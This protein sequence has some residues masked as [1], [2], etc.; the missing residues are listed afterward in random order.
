MKQ[1]SLIVSSTLLLL[2]PFTVAAQG[3]FSSIDAFSKSI[4]KGEDQISFTATG[5]LNGDG[6]EDWAGVVHRQRP[7]PSQTDQLYVLIRL[8][9]G[10]FHLAVKSI[11]TEMPGT[12]CCFVE[13]L[14][15]RRSSIY[16]Q[17]NAKDGGGDGGSM[18]ATTHQFKLQKGKW[19]LVGIKISLTEFSTNTTS[20]TDTDMNLLTGLVMERKQK[21]DNKPVTRSRRKR[22]ASCLFK[23]FDFSSRFCNQ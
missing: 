8:P 16:I 12:G 18:E 1:L 15:I 4:L 9:Q 5:D 6:L 21:G 20:E 14:Q 23:D 13:D 7:A 17:N 2:Y 10:G 11:E 19:R 22:F 3:N